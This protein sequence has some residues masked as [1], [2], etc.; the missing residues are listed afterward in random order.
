MGK[1]HAEMI[2]ENGRPMLHISY[3]IK[4]RPDLTRDYPAIDGI[5]KDEED[6]FPAKTAV[7]SDVENILEM[8]DND[9]NLWYLE[10][11]DAISSLLRT[12]NLVGDIPDLRFANE[13]NKR[14][15]KDSEAIK[16]IIEVIERAQRNLE[17]I[18]R[19]KEE[20]YKDS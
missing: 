5:T 13:D 14:Y 6:S 2:M 10:R 8:S 16:P 17:V 11:R 12:Y 19:V 15:M 3:L 18:K 7:R 4:K 1:R 20:D 9:F